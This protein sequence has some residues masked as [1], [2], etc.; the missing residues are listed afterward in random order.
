[1]KIT[2]QSRDIIST[3]QRWLNISTQCE[4]GRSQAYRDGPLIE[5]IVIVLSQNQFNDVIMSHTMVFWCLEIFREIK[6]YFY[7]NDYFRL[8]F[9]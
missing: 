1:M 5:G 4:R 8:K 9:Y 3:N 6:K 7:K 2:F